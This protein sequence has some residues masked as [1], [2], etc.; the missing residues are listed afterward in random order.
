MTTHIMLD[1]ETWGTRPG[2]DLRSIGAVRFKPDIGY[3]GSDDETFYVATDN[4]SCGLFEQPYCYTYDGIDRR[5]KYPLVRDPKTIEWWNEQSDEAKAAFSN[6]VDLLDAL[7]WFAAWIGRYDDVLVWAHGPQFDVS[8]LG[9]AYNA[10][11]L[12]EPWHYRAPRDTR[13]LF[14]VAGITD[15]SA[16]LDKHATGTTH[17]AL[18]DALCQAEAVCGAWAEIHP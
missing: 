1:L 11:G 14:D 9:A 15:H 16:W 3:V 17:N 7:V 10:L 13:T 4:P 2:C 8:I 18:D 6:P 12:P 5:F